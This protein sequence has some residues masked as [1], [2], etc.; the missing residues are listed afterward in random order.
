MITIRAA[1]TFVEPL[2]TTRPRTCWHQRLESTPLLPPELA[3]PV[4]RHGPCLRTPYLSSPPLLVH[5][6]P[7]TQFTYSGAIAWSENG[8]TMLLLRT[9][10]D[11]PPTAMA[12][13]ADSGP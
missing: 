8:E 12:A 6:H 1:Q 11:P 13:I 9:R 2:P 7:A 10:P 3:P 5:G 4:G